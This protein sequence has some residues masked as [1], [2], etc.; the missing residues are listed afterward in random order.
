M[1]FQHLDASIVELKKEIEQLGIGSMARNN[2]NYALAMLI[3]A[4][5]RMSLV[6]K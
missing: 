3:Q 6:L 2:L 5:M 1:N 4:R